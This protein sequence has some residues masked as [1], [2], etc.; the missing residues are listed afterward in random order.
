M[1]DTSAARKALK[2]A[3]ERIAAQQVRKTEAAVRLGM[4]RSNG[5]YGVDKSWFRRFLRGDSGNSGN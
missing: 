5:H 1:G 3:R 4:A 2:A